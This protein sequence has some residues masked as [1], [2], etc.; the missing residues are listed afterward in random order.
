MGP[1]F[2]RSRETRLAE[3]PAVNSAGAL[4]L[5]VAGL[6]WADAADSVDFDTQI[7]P[8]LTK[9]G[10]NAGACHGAAAGRGGFRLSLLGADPAADHVA[11]AQE[12]GARRI[13]TARPDRSLLLAKP[14]GRIDHEGGVPLD[15]D[16]PGY[17]LVRRWIAAGGRRGA[18]RTLLEFHVLPLA[19][20]VDRIGGAIELRTLAK[21]SHRP[22]D[23][24]DVTAWTA[25]TV[26]DASAVELT[27]DGRRAIV[28]RPGRHVIVAR[29]LD[30]VVPAIVSLPWPPSADSPPSLDAPADPIDAQVARTLL[31]LGLAPTPPVDDAAL[32]RRL[33]LDLTGRLP[34]PDE[35]DEYVTSDEPDKRERLIDR[36]LASDDFV[37]YWTFRLA[38]LLRLRAPPDDFSSLLAYH[39]WLREQVRTGRPFN[40]VAR[41]LLL[42][43]GDT[44]EV[45]PANFT[46]LSGDARRQAELVGELLLGVRLQCANCHNHPLDRWRQDDYH[47]LAAVFAR[48]ERGRI[49]RTT[50]RGAVTNPRTGEPATPRIP[51]L[52][53]LDPD[54]DARTALADWLTV[55]DN[56]YFARAFVNRIW[57]A[58]LGRGLVDPPDDLRETNPPTHPELLDRLTRQFVVADFDLRTTLR[59]I[60]TSAPYRRGA[61]DGANVE[62]ER[63]YAQ[64]ARRPLGAETLSDAIADVTG[65]PDRFGD[66]PPGSRA[67]SLVDPRTPAESLDVL[68]RCSR[69]EACEADGAGGGLPA[70][71]HQWNGPL[72]N[73]KIAS[74]EGRLHRLIDQGRSVDSIVE[75][76]YLRAF[77]RRPGADERTAWSKRLETTD[78][79]DR[80]ERLEDFVWSLLSSRDFLSNR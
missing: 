2:R 24:V 19:A 27:D 21:F 18:S 77:G 1:L 80:R 23:E 44:R 43:T 40:L 69:S 51:G 49:V 7:V 6:A 52:R 45:G 15:P 16:G 28:R 64:A 53:N 36:L 38:V 70:R 10:C 65:V 4:L 22:D 39:R 3:G 9:S 30:R 63:F 56:P 31:D 29:F 12:L 33:R 17:A 50:D 37:E 58:L 55:P 14:S 34:E 46:R 11:V 35:V 72:L 5:V 75:E 47:G 74:P 20:R 79:R 76:F 62:R 42:A 26:A 60:A 8:V 59:A 48:L 25:F 61:D 32:L 78:A 67:V 68:G 54:V 13:D 41:D 66:L 71:L 57:H 73:A